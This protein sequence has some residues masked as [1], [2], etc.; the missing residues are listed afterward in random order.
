MTATAPAT[1]TRRQ[2]RADETYAYAMR[3]MIG[4]GIAT[5]CAALILFA[6]LPN[7]ETFAGF[8]LVMG[9]FLVPA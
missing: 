6:G 5:I 2:P 4:V 8:S 1:S 3:F 9:L 7:V